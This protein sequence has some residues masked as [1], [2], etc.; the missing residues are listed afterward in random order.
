VL[1][2]VVGMPC[3]F[4]RSIRSLLHSAD[5]LHDK[6]VVSD[7]GLTA[8]EAAKCRA[9][10]TAADVDGSGD[11]HEAE[12]ADVL[13]KQTGVRPSAGEMKALKAR[14]GLVDGVGDGDSW[15]ARNRAGPARAP[16]G[17]PFHS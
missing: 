8:E 6:L 12:L 10:F 16:R 5:L 14:L 2:L 13:H 17:V 11:L 7:E 9:A 3:A 1:C 4:I 15:S